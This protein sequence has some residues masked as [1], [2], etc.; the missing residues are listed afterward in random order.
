MGL[1]WLAW[2]FQSRLLSLVGLDWQPEKLGQWGDTFGALN[3]LFAALGFSAVLLTL[4]LQQQ[5]IQD[6]RRQ[7][8]HERFESSFSELLKLIREARN[9]VQ[10][11]YSAAYRSST[12]SA[13]LKGIQTGPN[14]F[15]AAAREMRHWVNEA[16]QTNPT[17]TDAQIGQIYTRRIHTRFEGR[18]G[19]YFRLCY[20]ALNR[21][22]EDELLSGREKYAYG[23]LL[24]S[25]M[26]SHETVIAGFNGLSTVAKD[27]RELVIEFRLL[28]YV[29]AGRTRNILHRYYPAE[30][31]LPRD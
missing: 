5:Q 20:T 30:T 11:Q 28:K 15:K 4:W 13:R 22:R 9:E 14:A 3:A 25:Q 12:T 17:L 8:H 31:F 16:L 21:I 10:F 6:A 18:L 7:Q 26:S 29:P 27:F 23:R 2:A 24:R 1:L 19:P